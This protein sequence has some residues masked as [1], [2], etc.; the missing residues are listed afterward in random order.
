MIVLI[1]TSNLLLSHIEMVIVFGK[2]NSV[3]SLLTFSMSANTCFQWLFL[4][5]VMYNKIISYSK[6]KKKVISFYA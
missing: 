4:M 6:N 5:Q 2:T 3:S 1:D